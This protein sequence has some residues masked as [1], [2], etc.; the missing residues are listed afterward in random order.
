MKKNEQTAPQ[1]MGVAIIGL[2]GAVATTAIAGSLLLKKGVHSKAGLPLAEFDHFDLSDY[3]N[4]TFRGWDLYD[5]NL[6]EAAT[7]HGVLDKEQ[8]DEVKDELTQIKPW[9]AV[10]NKNFCEGVAL[11]DEDTSRSLSKQIDCIIDDIQS[12]E[13]ELGAPVVI[14]N[15][16]STEHAIDTENKVFQNL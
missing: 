4:I 15:L 5:Y 14:I 8:L 16:A 10:S 7:H 12:F 1:K 2:G 6:H 13:K 11:E 9:P 3:E